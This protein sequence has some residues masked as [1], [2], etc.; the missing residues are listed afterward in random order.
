MKTFDSCVKIFLF[1][2]AMLSV[3][4]SQPR[5]GLTGTVVDKA[6]SVPI[7]YALVV[8]YSEK[9]GSTTVVHVDAKGKF[10]LDL[11]PGM[12]DVMSVARSF[13]PVSVR[14]DIDYGRASTFNPK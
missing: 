10:E 5:K 2:V 14:V 8:A 9:D 1:C 11:A 13:A 3:G 4:N 6:E 7:P 12:Y